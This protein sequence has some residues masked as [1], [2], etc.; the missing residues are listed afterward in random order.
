MVAQVEFRKILRFRK[1]T[2]RGGRAEKKCTRCA[3]NT[4]SLESAMGS[5][6]VIAEKSSLSAHVVAKPSQKKSVY[7]SINH[8]LVRR[9]KQVITDFFVD[10]PSNV[11][12]F[13]SIH[14]LRSN[15]SFVEI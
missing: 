11:L 1:P 8:F 7:S 3:R 13:Y 14:F 5:G 12:V 15:I 6:G 9:L 2:G 10:W 4:P